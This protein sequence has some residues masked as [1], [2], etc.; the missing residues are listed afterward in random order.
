MAFA[1]KSVVVLILLLAAFVLLQQTLP[2]KSAIKIGADE[3]FALSKAVLKVNGYQPYVDFWNDQPPLHT[4]LLAAIIRHVSYSIL[5]PRL[6]TTV[7]TLML[8]CSVFLIVRRF[9]RIAPAAAAI[10]L[11]AASPGFLELSSSCM[12]EMPALATAV[13]GLAV[14]YSGSISKSRVMELCAGILF[15]IALQ[16]KFV[17]LLYL[18]IAVLILLL[19]YR[20]RQ[21]EHRWPGTGFLCFG[22][23][24]LTSFLAINYGTGHPLLIQ[25][26]ESWAAHAATQTSWAYG[27]PSEHPFQWW[28]LMRNWDVTIPGVIGIIALCR[29]VPRESIIVG[30]VDM[31]GSDHRCVFRTQA[32]V[33][34]LLHPQ[35]CSAVLVC[36]RGHLGAVEFREPKAQ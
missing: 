36:R 15:G 30:P 6:L 28:I 26:K 13:C 31:A 17:A 3:G 24:L 5:G 27:Y 35:F 34:V 29:S 18:P 33:A 23:A 19:R 25:L 4:I 14:L 8:F 11:L 1:G 32:M 16:I 7:F 22:V 10:V 9:S 21:P 20:L 2:L 12:V